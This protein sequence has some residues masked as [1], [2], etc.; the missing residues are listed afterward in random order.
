MR[1]ILPAAV[2]FWATVFAGFA[3]AGIFESLMKR[4][5]AMRNETSRQALDQETVIAGL[6][7]A[8]DIGTRNAIQTL[9]A[10]DGYYGN[11]MVKILLPERMQRVADTVARLGFHRQVDDFILSMNR[12]A[13][14]AAPRAGAIFIDA[15]RAMTFTDALDILRGEETAATEYFREKTSTRLYEDFKPI[16]VESMGRVGV[17]KAYRDM[18]TPYESLP[19]MPGEFMD[20]DHYVTN[21]ALEGLFFM[22][23]EEERK[24]RANPGARVTELLK[25]VFGP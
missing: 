11:H 17:T 4:I 3:H 6:K 12:A 8:L 1:K 23:A 14:A 19:F 9:S 2:F 16:I 25:T 24:I 18:M 15:I 7:E 13:E 21:K 5:P 20:L 22:V 10:R